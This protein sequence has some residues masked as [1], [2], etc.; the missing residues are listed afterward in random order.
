MTLFNK[1]ERTW[2]WLSDFLYSPAETASAI[3]PGD[4]SVKIGDSG[5]NEWLKDEAGLI[6]S[7]E[8]PAKGRV[9]A[10]SPDGALIYDSAIG[11]GDVYIPQGGFV[12]LAGVPGDVFKVMARDS[13][14]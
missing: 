14:Q 6:L 12:K 8:K 1:E 5:Y 2:A 10:F 3:N 7:F 4:N 11:K 9:I 13:I